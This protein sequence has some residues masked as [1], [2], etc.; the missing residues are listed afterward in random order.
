MIVGAGALVNRFVP[1]PLDALIGSLAAIPL[2]GLLGLFV[3]RDICTTCSAVLSANAERCPACQ[4][5]VVGAV[6]RRNDRLKAEEEYL[7]WRA[8]LP[9]KR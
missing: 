4:G 3:R 1:L 9:S 5:R 8:Q 2:L 6:A 7:A